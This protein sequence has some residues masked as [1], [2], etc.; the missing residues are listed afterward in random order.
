MLPPQIF[1]YTIRNIFFKL[2]F[3]VMLIRGEKKE[4]KDAR[5]GTWR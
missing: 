1:F 3:A 5:N 4:T 2:Y